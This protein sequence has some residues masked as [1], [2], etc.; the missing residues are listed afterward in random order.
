MII[1]FALTL[2]GCG[3]N[4]IQQRHDQSG[5][6]SDSPITSPTT[7]PTTAENVVTPNA[8]KYYS[9]ENYKKINIG[10]LSVDLNP[11]HIVSE[12]F[13]GSDYIIGYKEDQS[14]S[15][16]DSPVENMII[17]EMKNLKLMDRESIKSYL[18]KMMPSYEKIRIYNNI[19]DDS[20]IT[21]LSVIFGGSK[22]YCIVNFGDTSYL[23][24][25]NL[26]FVEDYIIDTVGNIA[27]YEE[28]K[29]NVECANSFSA[30]IHKSID[31][32][33]EIVKYEIIQGKN[34]KKYSAELNNFGE[35]ERSNFTLKN[36][37]DKN[38]LNIT[39]AGGGIEG[40]ITFIDVNLDGYVDI[41][42][43]DE[44]IGNNSTYNLYVWDESVNNFFKVKC[45]TEISTFEVYDGYLST[46]VR[47][48]ELIWKDNK[49]LVKESEE[50]Y[51]TD[52][53][54]DSDTNTKIIEN[55]EDNSS[56]DNNLSITNDKE[57]NLN[58]L[59]E[60]GLGVFEDQSFLTEFESFGKV[61]FVSG[62]VEGDN[63]FELRL[64][65]TDNNENVIYSFPS[66]YGNKWSVLT[67]LSA[68]AFKDVNKDGLKD[69]III[70]YYMTGVGKH[71]AEEFPVVGVYF[72]REKEF[73]DISEI[74]E[75]INAE[76]KNENIDEVIKFTKS[77]DFSKY[78]LL[79]PSKT[80]STADN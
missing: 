3:K 8:V 56:I 55:T 4:A 73:I 20:G 36:D 67:E 21:Y 13:N 11:F 17:R 7:T 69:I 34:G 32:E 40:D 43:L 70:A 77:I 46:W 64:Y 61:S 2:I 62:G 26:N 19:T 50:E 51:H 74:D 48:G 60:N 25:S 76:G 47:G 80:S 39:L 15:S 79:S 5:N 22:S 78:N 44:P 66:F 6:P 23:I 57:D 53:W 28:R 14:I 18:I 35:F 9:D 59:M 24:D 54:S 42:A 68:V 52:D 41:Q 31:Y 27:N 72:Q 12:T 38:M 37:N 63:P 33:I 10:K 49:T 29:Q 75:Q 30:S 16:N 45:D 58:F 71:G 1:V 65:L